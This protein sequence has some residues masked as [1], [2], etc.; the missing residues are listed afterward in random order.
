MKMLPSGIGVN[1]FTRLC[2]FDFSL[3]PSH[4]INCLQ[5]STSKRMVC[6]SDKTQSIPSEIVFMVRGVSSS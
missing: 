1:K 6:K 2:Y 3:I 5:I 4:I